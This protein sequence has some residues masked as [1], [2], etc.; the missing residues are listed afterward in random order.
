NTGAVGP[1]GPQGVKGDTGN[2]GAVG[3]QGPQG[4]AAPVEQ[5]PVFSYAT[6]R[7][8]RIDYAS[9]NFKLFSYLDG[10]LTAVDYNRSGVITRKAFTYNQDGTL[11]SIAETTL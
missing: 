11:A 6:G 2:T 1:Q 10:K 4:V 9:G 7:V 8:S 3:P 5:A